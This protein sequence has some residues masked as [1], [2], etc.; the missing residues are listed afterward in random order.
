MSLVNHKDVSILV[1]INEK[2]VFIIDHY[3]SVSF[4]CTL[5]INP[6]CLI[7]ANLQTLLLGLRYEELSW[8]YAKPSTTEDIDCLPCIFIQVT[9]IYIYLEI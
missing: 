3:E 6:I 8:D 4:I 5:L 9:Y 2:G 7:F 1:A